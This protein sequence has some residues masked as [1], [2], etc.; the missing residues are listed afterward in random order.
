MNST[1][2]SELA[3]ILGVD[4]SIL[5]KLDDSMIKITGKKGVPDLIFDKNKQMVEDT[6]RKINFGKDNSD[7]YYIIGNL[8]E[9]IFSHENELKKFL[10]ETPG[11]NIFEKAINFAKKIVKV[12]RGYFLKKENIKNILLARPPRHLLEYLGYNNID[13]LIANEDLTECFSALRFIESNE[14][15]HETFEKEY[16]RFTPDDFE[17]REIEIKVLGE[18]WHKIAEK[19]VAKKHHNVSHLKEFGVIFLNPISENISGKLLRDFLLFLHY[20]HEIEFYSKLF[21]KYAKMENFSDNLK[22]LLRGD[23]K[24]IFTVENG[25]WL[26]VQRYLSKENPKDP[27][28][29][30][31]RVNPEAL[32]WSRGERD[33]GNYFKNTPYFDLA[34]WSDLSWIGGFFKIGDKEELLSFDIED[35]IMSVV[36]FIEGQGQQFF[37]YHQR[38]AMWTKIFSEYAGGEENTEKL[39]IDNFDKGVIRFK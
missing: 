38:E 30:L 18:K 27:R 31:P 6:F 13:S 7:A 26:I 10:N 37:T 16:S 2:I 3:R 21:R 8:R 34:I 35:N 23:V 32:H 24:E 4:P 29:F 39:L 20:F 15:M 33:F 25:D 17:E 28:L 12:K 5:S 9:T 14:W 1:S 11:A 22:A 19:F 36:S